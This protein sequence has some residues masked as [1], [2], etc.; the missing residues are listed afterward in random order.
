MDPT[1]GTFSDSRQRFL[2]PSPVK[3]FRIM[4]RGRR[5]V[6]ALS[7]RAWLLYNHQ[8]RY[9][10][11]PISYERL[12]HAANFASEPCPEGIV[13]IAGNTLR[14]ITVNDLGTM[15][16]QTCIPLRY[17]PR[18]MCRIPGSNSLVIVE[19]DHNEYNEAERA[20]IS[21]RIAAESGQAM[22][23]V[24]KAAKAGG[25]DE[26]E[27]EE[28]ADATKTPVRGPMPPVDG[29]WASC[30][31]VVEPTSGNTLELLELT[32]NEAA[33]SVCTCRFS[34]RQEEAFIM[35][36]TAKNVTLHPRSAGPCF[37]SCYRLLDNRLQLLHKTPIED[38][39][40]TMIEFQGKLLVGVGKCLRLFELGKKQLLKKCENKL[41]PSCIVKLQ[42]S[43]DR[44]FVGDLCESILF[45]KY[46][47]N[48]NS[49]VIFADD[50]SSRYAFI[51]FHTIIIM[52]GPITNLFVCLLSP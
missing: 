5:G 27:E 37:I 10:Q 7:T 35:V 38:V 33:F 28:D 12:E 16:N 25:E 30:I 48:E 23:I 14:I 24:D 18:K 6:L 51:S 43:G 19:T 36:G 42:C 31:R 2:G 20:E 32:E 50:T 49:L 46:K 44:I 34:G 11:A 13:A 39:P 3:L 45:A 40:L 8:G 29:K 4:V 21:Q 15:F 41:F 26:D 1:A 17:T 47:R 9:H 22:E 52:D